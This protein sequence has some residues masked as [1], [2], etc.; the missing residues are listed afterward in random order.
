[1]GVAAL[2]A[3]IAH[4]GLGLRLTTALGREGAELAAR[5]P[6]EQAL[7]FA[8]HAGDLARLPTAQQASVLSLMSSQAGRVA[9]FLARFAERNPGKVLFTLAGTTLFL[10]HSEQILGGDEI[11]FDAAGNPVLIYKPGLVGRA[12]DR[13][14]RSLLLPLWNLLMAGVVVILILLG[15][16]ILRRRSTRA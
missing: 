15:W 1:M 8:R 16:N 14:L 3:E 11:A 12:G 2:R 10:T 7:A 4:P 13:L 5:P 6:A 9:A